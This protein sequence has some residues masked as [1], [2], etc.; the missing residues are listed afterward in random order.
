MCGRFAVFSSADDI[1]DRLGLSTIAAGARLLP[2]N[3]N[4]APT[5]NIPIVI[6]DLSLQTGTWG[7]RSPWSKTS[8]GIINAR[9]ESV[10]HKPTFS[11]AF[12]N[13]RCIVPANGYYEWQKLETKRKQ[14]WYITNSDN[15]LML[16]AGIYNLVNEQIS[17]AITTIGA[18]QEMSPIHHRMPVVLPS[19]AM[20]VWLNSGPDEAEQ[21]MLHTP[22]HLSFTKVSTRVNSVVNNGP[23]LIEPE[24]PLFAD[25]LF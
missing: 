6:P 16:F 14:P 10:A 3:W 11:D 17:V 13:R 23:S 12:V 24:V 15:S 25:T 18:N 21:L 22:Q 2:P 7:F 9:A 5:A 19:D 8:S 4:V 1:A 20:E